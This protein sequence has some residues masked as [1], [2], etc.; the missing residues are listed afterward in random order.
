MSFFQEGTKGSE[1]QMTKLGAMI[2][3]MDTIVILDHKS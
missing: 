1:E 2:K 3:K